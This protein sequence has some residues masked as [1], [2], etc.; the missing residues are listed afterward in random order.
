MKKKI[1]LVLIYVISIVV[2]FLLGERFIMSKSYNNEGTKV[3][4][5]D[6]NK[7]K[8]KM[9]AIEQR[10]KEL[11]DLNEK[12]NQINEE[13]RKE[14]ELMKSDLDNIKSATNSATNSLIELNNKAD[15]SISIINRLKENNK[16]L[17]EYFESM[18]NVVNKE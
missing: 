4:E 17:K 16:I 11:L 7:T 14:N 2:A 3:L 12:Q 18:Y 1:I 9:S 5:E 8:E 10:N 13:L 15:D 6:L